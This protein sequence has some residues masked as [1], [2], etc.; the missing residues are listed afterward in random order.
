MCCAPI[1]WLNYIEWLQDPHAPP[2]YVS[3]LTGSGLKFVC[4]CVCERVCPCP[5]VP[6][7]CAV[8]LGEQWNSVVITGTSVGRTQA[9]SA[10]MLRSAFSLQISVDT[11]THTNARAGTLGLGSTH[12]RSRE[13]LCIQ[14][15]NWS[16][17]I[18]TGSAGDACIHPH[19]VKIHARR[20]TSTCQSIRAQEKEETVTTLSSSICTGTNQTLFLCLL[21]SPCFLLSAKQLSVF[22]VSC[23]PVTWRKV[24]EVWH[25]LNLVWC[26]YC[27]VDMRVVLKRWHRRKLFINMPR[28]VLWM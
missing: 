19:T 8:P 16:A 10:F 6:S 22:A 14:W 28:S 3:T 5:P 4:V 1:G 26:V 7:G 17:C 9:R 12:S 21:V 13:R 27:V 2:P 15:G 11:D 24:F 25:R 18:F 20:H 23:S